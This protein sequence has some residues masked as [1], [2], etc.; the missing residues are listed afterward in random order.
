MKMN[1]RVI[2]LSLLILFFCFSGLSAQETDATT[3]AVPAATIEEISDFILSSLRDLR[4]TPKTVLLDFSPHAMGNRPSGFGDFLSAALRS[5]IVNTRRDRIV[6]RATEYLSLLRRYRPDFQLAEID[7]LIAG[8]LFRVG[9]KL[10]IQTLVIDSSTGTISAAHD[11]AVTLTPEMLPLLTDTAVAGHGDLFEPDGPDNPNILMENNP[12]DPHTLTA[13]DQDWYLFTA[14]REGIISFGTLGRLDTVITAYGPDSSS[15]ELAYNDDSADSSN[16]E[17][18]LMVS[19]GLTYYFQVQGYDEEQIGE[20][21]VTLNFEENTDPLEPNDT[22]SDASDFPIES[23]TL[24]TQFFPLNDIDWF[25]LSLP[26]S[27]GSEIR[28]TIETH[29][30]LDPEITL[31]DASGEIIGTDDDS[32]TDYN[33]LLTETVESGA[34]LY[35]QVREIEGLTGDYSIEVSLEP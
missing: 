5:R 7:F 9:E 33:A 4:S 29:G 25:E 19:P 15:L 27:P 32:G 3:S 14:D 1:T 23:G 24:E 20:Y 17:V 18:S 30:A 12:E 28:L 2:P 11:T 21:T 34:S 13:G 31:H 35:L 8:E 26:G 16:A 22:L 6:I 10:H